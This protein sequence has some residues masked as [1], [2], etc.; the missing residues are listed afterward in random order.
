MWR[1]FALCLVLALPACTAP[2]PPKK[3]HEPKKIEPREPADFLPNDLDFVLRIDMA[4][5]RKEPAINEAARGFAKGGSTLLRAVVPLLERSRA[6][7]V[8]ARFLPDGFHGDGVIAIDAEPSD[9]AGE[10]RPLD[11]SF[12]RVEATSD[13]LAIYE[14]A[15]D[16]RDEATLEVD[17]EK[18]G[19]V[20]A[21]AA[22]ADAV[23][24]VARAGA[25]A[26]RLDPAA[27]GLA[28]FV[29]K[30]A[31]PPAGSEIVDRMSRGLARYAGV[32]EGGDA[33]HL[34]A[35][36]IY[37]TAEGA[38]LAASF[39]R[40]LLSR[41]GAASSPLRSL[42]DSVTLANEAEVVRARASV[43]FALMANAH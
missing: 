29:G 30:S 17:L 43:P 20:L 14:R 42:A 3:P 21:T 25:D 15:T 11:E 23:L 1:R 36:L 41:L 2:L 8:G 13:R 26:D 38:A 10:R 28:S 19:V 32:V 16:A 27:R 24:R 4:R 35:E 12:H 40:T 9:E 7:F 34:E 18:G 39:A 33:I 5:L 37:T 31:A 6:I 22:E